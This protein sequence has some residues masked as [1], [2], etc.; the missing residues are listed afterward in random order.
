MTDDDSDDEL[1][2]WMTRR[3]F[4]ALNAD[5]RARALA[6]LRRHVK[7]VASE[8]AVSFSGRAM[9]ADDVAKAE[10][11]RRWRTERMSRPPYTG[12]VSDSSAPGSDR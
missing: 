3:E 9:T 4:R 7:A 5:D 1:W 11:A 12:G 8:G 10:R 2:L 6:A